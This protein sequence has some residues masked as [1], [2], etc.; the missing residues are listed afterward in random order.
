MSKV[1]SDI[2][3]ENLWGLDIGCKFTNLWGYTCSPVRA[4]LNAAVDIKFA[5]QFSEENECAATDYALQLTVTPGIR[6]NRFSVE[7]GP[8]IAYAALSDSREEL[9]S[10]NVSGMDYGIRMGCTIHFEK[11]KIDLHYDMGL[12]DQSKQFK[13]NDLMLTYGF[14]F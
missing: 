12:S 6:I 10:P 1:S 2:V 5:T 11:Q 8:Y 9:L 14:L 3:N 7:V 4:E 13:K